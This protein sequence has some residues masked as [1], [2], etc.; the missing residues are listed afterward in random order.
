MAIPDPRRRRRDLMRRLATHALGDTP[1]T[2]SVPLSLNY[3]CLLNWHNACMASS[4]NSNTVKRKIYF[5]RLHAGTSTD[6]TPKKVDLTDPIKQIS[7]LSFDK[8]SKRYWMQ[9][10]GSIVGLWLPDNATSFNE[11]SLATVRHAGLPRKEF[12]GT[13]ADIDLE[14][15]AGL[16]E[17]T[18]IKLFSDNIVGVEFNFHGPR[19]SRLPF[20]LRHAYPDTQDFKIE[21]LLNKDAAENLKKHREIRVLEL[22]V[23]PS[24]VG[25]VREANKSLGAALGQLERSGAEVI[26]ITLRPEPRQRTPLKKNIFKGAKK[27]SRKNDLLENA[28]QFKVKAINDETGRVDDINLLDDKLV[29]TQNIK[30]FSK[31]SR[32]VD[33][34]EAYAAIQTA[35]DTLKPKLLEAASIS[36]PK[37]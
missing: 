4:N 17:P 11:F 13:L 21:A 33:P 23:R 24:Y 32:A 27:L 36:V 16:H 2:Q 12:E 31:K 15:G 7:K 22:Q 5:Y 29:S 19:P 8:D 3:I 14:E 37:D 10:D 28:I 34:A 35:Y 30:T 20:Y 25:K 6:G 9:P 1:T 26:G 18:H